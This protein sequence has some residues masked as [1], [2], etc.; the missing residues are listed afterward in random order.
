MV[1]MLDD[2][3]LGVQHHQAAVVAERGGLLCDAL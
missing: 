2:T 3:T 1:A